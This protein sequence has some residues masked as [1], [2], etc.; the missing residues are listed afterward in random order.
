MTTITISEPAPQRARPGLRTARRSREALVFGGAVAV[1]LVHALDDA[2]FHRQPGV[3]LGRHALA[4]AVFV[5]LGLAAVYAFPSVR[6]ALRSALALFF[7][8]LTTVGGMLHVKHIAGQGA[9]AS[10][11]TGAVAAAAG[12]ALV[13]L[14]IAIPWLHRGEGAAGPRRRWAHR[15][16]AVPLGLL[17]FLYTVVP[18]SIALTETHKFREPIG[19]PP[20]ARTTARSRST[21]ATASTCP[22][23]IAR[24]RTAPR[25]SSCTGAAATA[26]A[27]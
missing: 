20:R 6:P 25:S 13:G 10:D 15:V 27:L 5:A 7:G 4:A 22:A 3:G 19:A 9:A 23:G 16:V 11:L 17:A 2:F 14:A 1:A 24:R 26:P 8:A 18:M 21:R 12:L